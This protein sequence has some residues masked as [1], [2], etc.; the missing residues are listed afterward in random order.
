MR[1]RHND[2]R[3]LHE[4][5]IKY[6]NDVLVIHNGNQTRAALDLEISR[7]TLRKYMKLTAN[8]GDNL[9]K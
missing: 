2:I 1:N 3:P 5:I 9:W 7:G 6:I 4:V 8:Y